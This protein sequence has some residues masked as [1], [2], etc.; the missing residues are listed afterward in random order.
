MLTSLL[1]IISLGILFETVLK[2][3]FSNYI[4]YITYILHFQ[5]GEKNFKMVRFLPLDFGQVFVLY[6]SMSKK[7]FEKCH[8]CHS[9]PATL[10]EQ[11]NSFYI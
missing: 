11:F 6:M 5:L 1:V 3:F 2:F 7:I 9:V 4:S 8:A 10:E